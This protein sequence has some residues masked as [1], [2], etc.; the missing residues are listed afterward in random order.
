MRQEEAP[1]VQNLKQISQPVKASQEG[2][3]WLL[4]TEALFLAGSDSG[5]EG[6]MGFAPQEVKID[7]VR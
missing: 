6:A 5:R 7:Y 2:V 3:R 1:L 4:R